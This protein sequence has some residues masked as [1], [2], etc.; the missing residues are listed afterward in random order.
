[1]NEDL[2]VIGQPVRSEEE[3][4]RGMA[5][6]RFSGSIHSGPTEAFARRGRNLTAAKSS[7]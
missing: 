1:M 7:S 6:T 3:A 4:R 5:I 2:V